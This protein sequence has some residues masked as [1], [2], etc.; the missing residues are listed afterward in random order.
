MSLP[1]LF[2]SHGRDVNPSA[3]SH[4]TINPQLF[5]FSTMNE[6]DMSIRDVEQELTLVSVC[7]DA[8]PLS[9]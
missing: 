1:S 2:A 4:L 3:L 9:L 8:G 7:V 5:K 6:A